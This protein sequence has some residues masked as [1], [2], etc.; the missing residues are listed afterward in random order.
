MPVLLQLFSKDKFHKIHHIGEPEMLLQIKKRF[1]KLSIAS[2]VCIIMAVLFLIS[3]IPLLRLAFCAHPAG[4]DYAYG[5]QAHLAWENTHSLAETLK[6]A[7]DTV[8]SYYQT[9]Q[10]TYASIFLM[11]L[12]P[13]VFSQRLY[14]LT[15]FLMLGILA[16]GTLFLIRVLFT[17]YLKL[18]GEIRL[19]LALSVLTL[20]IQVPEEGKSAFFWYNGALHYVFMHGCMLL[21]LAFLLL[22]LK[23]QNRTSQIICLAV[24]CCLAVITGGSNYVTTLITPIL[25]AFILFFCLLY[26]Q[27]RTLFLLMPLAVSITGLF[28]NVT[29]PGN[30]VRMAVQT[31]SLNAAEAIYYSFVY[32]IKGVA[33]WTNIYVLFFSLLIFPFLFKALLKT[34]FSFPLPGC[35]AALSFCTVAA[36]YTPSLYSMGHV[37][38]FERTLNIMRMLFYLLFMLNLLYAAG[39]LAA[40]CRKYGKAESAQGFL[41]KLKLQ[42][43]RSFFAGMTAFFFGLL[44]FS[45]KDEIT[46]LS[47]ADS[48]IKGYAQSYHEE[49]LYRISLLTMENVDEVWVPNFSVCPPLLDPQELST[50]P[51]DYRNHSV[52]KWY[53][54]STLHMSEVY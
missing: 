35:V 29:A 44:L 34:D 31:A 8:A 19:M 6:A 53:G 52:A 46:S 27:R 11:A 47:A 4:D 54:I 18:P 37:Y 14:P 15:T 17:R 51:S 9:W 50:D 39:W 33:E 38:I 21:L 7:A 3:L 32:A 41:T 24:S 43:G 49:S 23:L 1:F 48:L 20:C 28:I 10:G 36:T 2:R 22:F 25:T 40:V 13:A 26:R 12:Q 16:A 42:F 5:L 45:D 30:A